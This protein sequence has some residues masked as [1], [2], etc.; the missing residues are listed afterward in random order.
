MKYLM[1]ILGI[2]MTL[3]LVAFTNPITG[4][5]NKVDIK[6]SQIVWKGHKV[7]GSHE[8]KLSLKSGALEFDSKNTLT[9]GRFEIDMAS[10]TNTDLSG[11]S[12][13]KLLGHLKSDDFFSVDK[14]PVSTFVITKATKVKGN[15]YKLTGDLTIKGITNPVSFNAEV[16]NSNTGSKATAAIKVDRTLYDVRYGS[17][18]FFENLGDKAIYDHFDLEVELVLS[19]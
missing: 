11:G 3:I 19:K 2:S 10:M 14:Y 9:G 5:L 18:K 8:G 6:K 17:G 13:D 7:T 12:S 15:T 4:N 16:T 1:S